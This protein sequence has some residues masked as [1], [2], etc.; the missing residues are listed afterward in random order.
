MVEVASVEP[1]L[2]PPLCGRATRLQQ[3]YDK[4]CRMPPLLK[5]ST[6]Q[7][8]KT[9][10]TWQVDQGSLGGT[11]GGAVKE[12]SR[13]SFTPPNG[14]PGMARPPNASECTPDSLLD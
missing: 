5:N 2:D 9:D 12:W 7:T 3:S 13:R 14:F 10:A 6:K 1:L 4:N 11:W 8:P